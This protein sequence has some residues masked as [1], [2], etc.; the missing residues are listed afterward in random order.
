ML[1]QN[2]LG[3]FLLSELRLDEFKD[4]GV[5]GVH[6]DHSRGAARLAAGLYGAR[7]FVPAPVERERP[8]AEPFP[9]I[10]SPSLRIEEM[11]MPTPEPL[12]NMLPSV[13]WCF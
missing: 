10:G 2:H 4:I 8:E 3:D 6:H 7:H 12:E 5:V 11:F 1:L 9:A 13:Y